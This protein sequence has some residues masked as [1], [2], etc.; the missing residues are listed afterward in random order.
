M[1]GLLKF[2]L[3]QAGSVSAVVVIAVFFIRNDT[4]ILSV[5]ILKTLTYLMSSTNMSVI[6]FLTLTYFIVALRTT[7]VF[8]TCKH[9]SMFLK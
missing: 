3:P 4:F 9:I 2:C 1:T 6:T 7:A 5:F 8:L